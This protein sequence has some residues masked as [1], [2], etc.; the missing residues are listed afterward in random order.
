[1]GRAWRH[2]EAAGGQVEL[3]SR[4][5][6]WGIYNKNIFEDPFGI[7]TININTTT[8]EEDYIIR[9]RLIL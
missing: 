7:T 4:S 3:G 1:M 8:T 5:C 2:R 9:V 6:F